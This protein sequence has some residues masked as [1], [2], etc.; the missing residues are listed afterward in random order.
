MTN[1]EAAGRARESAVGD[2]RDRI[3]DTLAVE[4]RGGRQHLAHAGTALRPLVADDED[5]TFLVLALVDRLAG[6]FL[7]IEAAYRAAELQVLHAGELHD[8]A[9]IGRAACR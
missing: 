4:R 8:G 3:A 5:A 7:T 6:V 1:A 9:Q 2:Q